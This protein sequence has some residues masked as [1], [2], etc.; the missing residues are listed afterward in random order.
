MKPLYKHA[1]PARL[2]F[3]I[4]M[5]RSGFWV[6]ALCAAVMVGCAGPENKLGRGINNMLEFTRGGEIRRS[7]EQTALWDGTGQAYTTGFIRGFNRSVARTFVGTVEV[8]TFPIPPYDPLYTSTNAIYPDFSVRNTKYPWGGLVLPEGPVFPA[9]YQPGLLS[10][11]IFDRDT[12]LGFS[13]G[14]VFPFVQGSRFR[15]FDN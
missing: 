7:M 8:L 13:G 12:S 2:R 1:N 11:S 9:N 14:D 15:I 10:D 5:H 6:V 4:I 3:R